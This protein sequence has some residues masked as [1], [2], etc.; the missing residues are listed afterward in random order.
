MAA[1]GVD[2]TKKNEKTRRRIFSGCQPEPQIGTPRISLRGFSFQWPPLLIAGRGLSVSLSLYWSAVVPLRLVKYAPVVI[3]ADMVA[4]TVGN[5]SWPSLPFMSMVPHNSRG[6]CERNKRNRYRREKKNQTR[7]ARSLARPPIEK[8][9]NAKRR[10][11]SL[12]SSQSSDLMINEYL[13]VTN[14]VMGPD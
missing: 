8:L 13:G 7:V 11:L 4:N 14:P 10:P 2:D 12:L 1:A 6:R 3:V 5:G 9:H